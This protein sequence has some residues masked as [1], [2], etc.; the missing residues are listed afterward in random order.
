MTWFF[1]KAQKP[2][3][4]T[5]LG[6]FAR[7]EF[8][9]KN[10]AVTHNYL[11]APNIM[12][13]FRKNWRLNPKKTYRQT[14]G[15]TDRPY[16]IESFW[17]RP[18]IQQL[19]L[20]KWLVVNQSENKQA[21]VSKLRANIRSCRAKNASKPSLKDLKDRIWKIKQYSNYILMIINQNILAILKTFLNLQKNYET[22]HQV[23]FHTCYYW[24]CLQSF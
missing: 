22:L 3:F 15:G 1:Y 6:H 23:N 17:L 8:F 13:S 10:L 11:W 16:F 7:W 18:G 5:I 9:P 2:C 20:S 21:K 19:L 4:C 12:L 24:T 14:E